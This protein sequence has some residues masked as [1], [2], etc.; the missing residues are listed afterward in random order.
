MQKKTTKFKYVGMRL[1]PHEVKILERVQAELKR[2]T[3]TDTLRYLI[4]HAGEKIL[5]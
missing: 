2:R 1:S 5:N 3:K 4:L